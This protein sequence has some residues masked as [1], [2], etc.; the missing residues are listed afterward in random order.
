ML[1]RRG[2]DE[3]A[4][5]RNPMP[6]E[7]RERRVRELLERL[8]EALARAGYGEAEGLGFLS[9]AVAGQVRD[10]ARLYREQDVEVEPEFGDAGSAVATFAEERSAPVRVELML[11]DRSVQ[12]THACALP[13]QRRLRL[14]VETDGL[15]RRVERLRVE[16]LP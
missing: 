12:R 15:C 2:A 11:T 14:L 5:Q 6:L 1:R 10:L 9:P 3:C 7:A 13:S 8:V 4:G 16:T